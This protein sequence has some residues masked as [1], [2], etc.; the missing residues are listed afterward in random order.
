MHHRSFV[1]STAFFALCAG[2]PGS[3]LA[4]AVT[5]PQCNGG[6]GNC[7]TAHPGLG[8][9]DI[10]C[11]SAVC[12]ADP[13]CCSVE[14]DGICADET[15]TNCATV[16]LTEHV[17]SPVNGHWYRLASPANSA[18]TTPFLIGNGYYPASI[19]SGK[20]NAWVTGNVASNVPG[21]P[22]IVARI[23]LG[24]DAVEG[25]F[26]WATGEATNYVNWAP[27][28][29]NNVGNEDSV[30]LGGYSGLWNDVS[31]EAA[32]MS[33]GEAFFPACGTGGSCFA[34]HGPGCDNDTCCNE[35]C[36]SDP[37]CCTTYWDGI[38]VGE[39]QQWCGGATTG[40]AVVNPATRH[41][42]MIVS[43]GS[44]L[45][46]QKL[47]MSM[48]G[49]LASIQSAAENEWLRRN[50]PAIKGNPSQFLIGFNDHAVEGT[51]QWTTHE[52][53]TYT[54]WYP[55]EPNDAGTGEDIAYL[56]ADGGWNDV[57]S[58]AS[59]AA[60]IEIPC[61]GDFDGDGNVGGA[62]LATLLGA[63]GGTT[64]AADLDQD[65]KVDA[66]DLAILLGGWG[67]C[68]TSNACFANLGLGSDQ[69][70]CTVCVCGL[71]PFCCETSWD[72][73]CADEA[74]NECNGACQCAG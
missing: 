18:V 61:V 1:V 28:E 71:D 73:I 59:V 66:A 27:G 57:P 41:R 29:P 53:V 42:Y 47:A 74:G 24:D 15:A 19:T 8:C 9:N 72:G 6:A 12:Q 36:F 11:C 46:A 4:Y 56:G 40:P 60:I 5:P 10:A 55:G 58:T 38:C 43:T 13:F 54:N 20:E 50:F 17:P 65:S 16:F 49:H 64:S 39:A 45:Q 31:V 3:S 22:P 7:F 23:G 48:G 32:R 21:F 51:F 35:T 25:L 26:V 33:I 37:Y 52:P 34:V 63:W 44:W 62:D 30:E 67:P 2:L 70:G 68:P 14:W 69:P